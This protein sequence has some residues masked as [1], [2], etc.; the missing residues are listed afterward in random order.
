[1]ARSNLILFPTGCSKAVLTPLIP[2]EARNLALQ[3]R[4]CKIPCDRQFLE[5]AGCGERLWQLAGG[6]T[7]S[8]VMLN[9]NI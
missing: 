2:G 9:L 7:S 6:L 1:M 8:S 3:S 5:M 4:T